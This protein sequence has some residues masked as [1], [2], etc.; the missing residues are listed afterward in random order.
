MRLPTSSW[1]PSTAGR[2]PSHSTWA[3]SETQ[4]PRKAD[5]RRRGSSGRPPPAPAPRTR[6]GAIPSPHWLGAPGVARGGCSWWPHPRVEGCFTRTRYL[7]PMPMAAASGGT[8][9]ASVRRGDRPSLVMSGER[10]PRGQLEE[11]LTGPLHRTGRGEGTG[12]IQG[13]TC[14]LRKATPSAESWQEEAICSSGIA[15]EQAR[16]ERIV[17]LERQ[18]PEKIWSH[19]PS[20]ARWVRSP[21][22]R[23][24]T[25]RSGRGP[26]LHVGG[27][28]PGG[29]CPRAAQRHPSRAH[30]HIENSAPPPGA[31]HPGSPDGKVVLDA[32][33]LE[34]PFAGRSA[35]RDSEV[36]GW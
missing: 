6:P 16:S 26:G 17:R 7:A 30:H 21:H 36:P 4:L 19:S 33:K 22:T 14:S 31:C 8:Q 24:T 13:S 3:A 1:W 20:P 15:G 12:G 10:N 5:S 11:P 29:R 35:V 9:N 23:P 32:D 2:C 25:P 28:R 27:C 34:D 18:A